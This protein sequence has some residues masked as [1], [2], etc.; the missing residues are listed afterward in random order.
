MKNYF[1]LFPDLEKYFGCL[2][3]FFHSK[4]IEGFFVINPPYTIHA[5]NMTFHHILKQFAST[6]SNLTILLMIP[7]WINENRLKLNKVCSSQLKISNYSNEKELN[8]KSLIDSKLIKQYLLYCKNN[9]K[10]YNY[11]Q[12]HNT[13]FSATT[14][15]V[16]SNTNIKYNVEHILGKCNIKII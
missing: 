1:G 3:N 5:M 16:M 2:G 11:I 6:K 7:T 4:F 15:I 12:E 8:V 9:F 10:H 13:S 14:I